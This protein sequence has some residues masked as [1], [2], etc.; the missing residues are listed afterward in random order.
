M[1]LLIGRN[2][3]SG[4]G[5]GNHGNVVMDGQNH[6][7]GSAPMIELDGIIQKI[8]QQPP[9][10]ARIKCADHVLLHCA[11]NF[12]STLARLHRACRPRPSAP[13]RKGLPFP[14]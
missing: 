2:A 14:D 1:Y 3:A 12:D 11:G 5:D 13:T 8:E 10:L 4:I 9:D 6:V 7:H